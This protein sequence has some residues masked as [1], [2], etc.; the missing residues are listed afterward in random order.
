MCARFLVASVFQRGADGRHA[1][2]VF[3]PRVVLSSS[4]RPQMLGKLSSDHGVLGNGQ[5]TPL[6]PCLSLLR[7]AALE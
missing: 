1:V 3:S 4:A 6:I 7:H 2:P 5:E